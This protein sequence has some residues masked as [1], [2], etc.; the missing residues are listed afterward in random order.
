[1]ENYALNI[2]NIMHPLCVGHS[3]LKI[4][5]K[6]EKILMSTFFREKKLEIDSSTSKYQ[7]SA[8]V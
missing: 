6:Y 2:L 1:M 5:Q 4:Q 7:K 3:S 8:Q